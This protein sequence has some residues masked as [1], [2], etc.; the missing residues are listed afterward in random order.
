MKRQG[1]IFSA[2]AILG[3]GTLLSRILGFFRDFLMA[4]VVAPGVITDAFIV[5]LRLP[6]LFRRLFAEGAFNGA[7]VPQFT[8]RLQKQGQAE[9][10]RFGNHALA[11]MGVLMFVFCGAMILFMP[12]VIP[13]L[14]PGFVEDV[15][16]FALTVHLSRI[17]FPYLFCMVLSALLSGILSVHG[18]F[19]ATALAPVALNLLLI[20]VLV[21]VYLGFGWDFVGGFA[22]GLALA[23]LVS[24]VLQ[25]FWLLCHCGKV[26][27]RIDFVLP[28]FDSDMGLLFRRMLPS[29]LAGAVIQVNLLVGDIL[30]SLL[31]GSAISWLFFADRLVQLPLGVVGVALAVAVLPRLSGSVSS[32]DSAGIFSYLSGALKLGIFL[33]LPAMF[34]LIFMSDALILGLFGYGRFGGGDVL[35]TSYALR[36]GA[37]GLVGFVILKVFLSLFFAYG[38]TRTPA[39]VSIFVVILNGV[40]AYVL[41]GFMGHGGIALAGSVAGLVNMFVLGWLVIRF[42]WWWL[43]M[44]FVWF[45]VRVFVLCFLMLFVLW[46]VGLIVGDLGAYDGLMRFLVLGA[47]VGAGGLVYLSLGF[48]ELKKLL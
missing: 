36:M 13:L 14:V 41:M 38:D 5:A 29:L 37:I 27:F 3:S 47:W 35:A 22:V 46:V 15:E 19:S 34:A 7:F 48:R 20:M 40:L 8:D 33:T 10:L 45:L 21:G 26:G 9:A 17:T 31:G 30:A 11:W 42:G 32:G 43:N 16:K 39:I 1:S 28:R 23:V 44:D 18:K 12:Y 4:V 2:F 24:G 25:L 6:N